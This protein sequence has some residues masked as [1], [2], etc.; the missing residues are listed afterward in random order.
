MWRAFH[1]HYHDD[2][3]RLLAALR[4]RWCQWL[5]QGRAERLFFVR[6]WLGG[7]HLRIRGEWSGDADAS[8]F[9]QELREW[10]GTYFAL[11]PST[12]SW[13]AER[14]A[15]VDA[16]LRSSDPSAVAVP[17]SP[18][19]CILECAYHPEEARYGGPS[20]M[21]LSHELF[22]LSSLVALHR[23]RLDPAQR[24]GRLENLALVLRLLLAASTE[25]EDLAALCRYPPESARRIH[26]KLIEQASALFDRQPRLFES[27]LADAEGGH[28]SPTDS[29]EDRLAQGLAR[30]GHYLPGE[31]RRRIVSSHVHMT[32]NR[33]GLDN[34]EE[35]LLLHWAS[36]L[37][38]LVEPVR[39]GE[40]SSGPLAETQLLAELKRLT[41]KTL[42]AVATSS[43]E[44]A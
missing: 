30:L 12:A 9:V 41:R 34:R 19:E 11:F 14:I 36:R 10:A 33:L 22:G 27:A 38:D 26:R 1:L 20:A 4:P 23:A 2:Q 31:E 43:P 28:A 32:M 39:V 15:R 37:V 6:Y 13:S 7:P 40:R 44:S 29:P 24:P 18:D 3:D 42:W 17:A 8:L 35:L 5:I 25:I 16:E 21:A